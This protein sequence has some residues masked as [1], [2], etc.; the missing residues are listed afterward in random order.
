LEQQID[1]VVQEMGYETR[2]TLSYDFANLHASNVLYR[3]N[4]PNCCGSAEIKLS[5]EIKENQMVLKKYEI[6]KLQ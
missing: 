6:E 2:N 1:K 5:F 4:D 3:S